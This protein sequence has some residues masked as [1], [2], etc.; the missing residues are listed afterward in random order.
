[1]KRIEVFEQAIE[2]KVKNLT[3]VNGKIGKKSSHYV[4]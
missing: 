4:V 2:N 1:M 3:G